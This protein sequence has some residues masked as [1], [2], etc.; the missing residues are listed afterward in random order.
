MEYRYLGNTGIKVSRMCFGSLTIG[1]L[2]ADLSVDDG[3]KCIETAMDH[4]VN[5]IDTADL[6][7]TYPHIRQV[8]KNK[9]DMI[10]A[11]KSYAYDTK[12]ADETLN[13]ALKGIGR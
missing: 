8:I 12:T 2:Q 13:R 10:V 9:P 1:P 11:T 5:F 6:Y 7:G 4:G 3:L